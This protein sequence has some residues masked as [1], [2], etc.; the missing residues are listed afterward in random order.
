LCAAFFILRYCRQRQ[1]TGPHTKPDWPVFP[2]Y[3]PRRS[4]KY[5]GRRR[6][7]G[8]NNEWTSSHF[9]WRLEAG[10]VITTPYR[11]G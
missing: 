2:V 6:L 3:D 10:L 4:Q 7:D 11:K 8:A 1:A 5:A 9:D